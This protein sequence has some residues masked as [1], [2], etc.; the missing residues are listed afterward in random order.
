VV[1]PGRAQAEAGGEGVRQ[2]FPPEA[3]LGPGACLE[4]AW[5]VCAPGGRLAQVGPQP[6]MRRRQGRGG[7]GRRA[8]EWPGAEGPWPGGRGAGGLDGAPGPGAGNRKSRC[9][10]AK[11]PGA[12]TANG[13]GLAS[14]WPWAG[15]RGG[16]GEA[17]LRGGS[18]V[19]APTLGQPGGGAPGQG[20]RGCAGRAGFGGPGGYPRIKSACG[21]GFPVPGGAGGGGQGLRGRLGAAWPWGCPACLG[22]APWRFPHQGIRMGQA[23]RL[24]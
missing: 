6:P 2:G 17:F 3:A 13:K 5:A 20:L 18:K 22:R 1:G 8:A 24:P 7:Q 15:S 19:Q 23:C 10:K 21:T 11:D 12:K 9:A 14:A 4:H 16:L